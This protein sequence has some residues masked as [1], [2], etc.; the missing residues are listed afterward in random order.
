M[1]ANGRTRIRAS[2]SLTPEMYAGIMRIAQD[3]GH[4]NFSRVVQ[5][6]A[7]EELRRRY[8]RD[9]PAVIADERVAE[10]VIA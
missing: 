8:G 1:E 7:N 9:W 2:L 4:K 5:D 6:L 3:D 10:P